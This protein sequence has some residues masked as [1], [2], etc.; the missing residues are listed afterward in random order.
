MFSQNAP[1]RFRHGSPV[2][3]L[4]ERLTVNQLVAG[5]S[6]ARGANF[7]DGLMESSEHSYSPPVA[8][9][10]NHVD[11]TLPAHSVLDFDFG[12]GGYE[13]QRILP[14]SLLSAD[15]ITPGAH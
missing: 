9:G 2:A 12:L 10:G 5:S 14:F 3:Q 4:V 13:V 6:P 15:L 8:L 11:L 7:H 1:A